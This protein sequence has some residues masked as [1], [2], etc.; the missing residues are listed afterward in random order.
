MGVLKINFLI[1]DGLVL[2]VFLFFL[3]LGI[4]S[5]IIRSFFSFFSLIFATL[6]SIYISSGL[7]RTIYDNFI[8]E[9]VLSNI[10][11]SI[12]Y[13]DANVDSLLNL[14]PKF[15]S[16]SFSYYGI[17]KEDLSNIISSVSS[18]A[19]QQIEEAIAPVFV[20]IVRLS[21]EIVLFFAIL[22]ILGFVTRAVV[23]I[24]RFCLPRTID[25]ALGAV[26]GLLKGYIV[27]AVLLFCLR[28]LSQGIDI[29]SGIFSYGS[30]ESTYLFKYFYTNN[31]VW[32]VVEETIY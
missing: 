24:I 20:D 7:A 4:M 11:S 16:N 9:S 17:T 1:L 32:N 2:L 28:S 5:G 3:I 30:I 18:D 12:E 23:S 21:L 25:S 31:P 29:S 13:S 6:A 10:N 19:A 22:F 27:L 14:L 15:V 26:F 8:R